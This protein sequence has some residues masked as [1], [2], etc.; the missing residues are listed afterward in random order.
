MLLSTLAIGLLA[1]FS[2]QGVQD[3]S[4]APQ[5]LD[6]AP[7]LMGAKEPNAAFLPDGRLIA[8][9]GTPGE[10]YVAVESRGAARF[11]APVRAVSIPGLELGMRRGPR[12]AVT[13]KSWVLTA[14]AGKRGGSGDL[15]AFRSPNEGKTWVG[16]VRI[17]ETAGSAEEGLHAMCASTD[18]KDV[19]CVWLDDR[20]KK[21]ELYFAESSDGGAT[22]S[23]NRLVY[24]SPEGSICECC[25]PSL[26]AAG[27]GAYLAMWRNSL[28]GNR[29][30][31]T[32]LITADGVSQATKQGTGSWP[33][34]A[35]PMD[36]GAVARLD[37]GRTLSV[38]RRG[39]TVYMAEGGQELA[40][41]DGEQPWVAFNMSGVCA[42]WQQ[43]KRGPI[44]VRWLDRPGQ[45][46]VLNQEG[47][48]PVVVGSTKRIAVLWNGAG[49]PKVCF[50]E[51]LR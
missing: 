2:S 6:L 19:A 13:G 11:A 1:G 49:G 23:P 25:H 26:V 14:V 37:D 47:Q 43:G 30:M 9:F 36:G 27:K 41:G 22:W 51:A 32:A 15:V 42:A 34:K 8:A 33:L 16:P 24:R 48:F 28:G 17:N 4:S 18:G 3:A 39:V 40:L 7:G 46:H 45:P 29:D 21:M 5:I 12:I 50:L 35:C 38:F 31:Y 10:I 20:S 44:V